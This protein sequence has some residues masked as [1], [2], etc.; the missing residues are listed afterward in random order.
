MKIKTVCQQTGLSDRTVRYY[1]E[2][3]L[4]SPRYTENYLGRKTFDFSPEEVKGLQDI[5]VLRKFGFSIED[6]RR[7]MLN[8][9]ESIA[10][11]SEVRQRKQELIAENTVALEALCRLDG[12]KV[13]TVAELAED[14]AAPAM[15]NPLPPEDR[16]ERVERLLWLL[17]KRLPAIVLAGLP[18]VVLVAG[19]VIHSS[20]AYPVWD[21]K[22]RYGAFLLLLPTICILL[23][24]LPRCKPL[25]ERWETV[26]KWVRGI[27]L[28]LCAL[29]VPVVSFSWLV[30]FS[31]GPSST[32]NPDAYLLLDEAC[33]AKS[34]RIFRELF[35]QT[36]P[37]DR[38]YYYWYE[39]SVSGEKYD[40]CAQWTLPREEFEAEVMRVEELFAQFCALKQNPPPMM[41]GSNLEPAT[42]QEGKYTCLIWY[43]RRDD[44]MP[45]SPMS[46]DYVVYIFDYHPSTR[47][48]RYI[49]CES[50]QSGDPWYLE[51][52]W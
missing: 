44:R 21:G 39:E 43:Q 28:V 47:Q 22:K 51:M 7:M 52:D 9:W 50:T 14:L 13:Y 25:T 49:L 38:E 1:I 6:I 40:I 23:L 31:G 29:Y 20:Y 17:L 32:T 19:L 3:G 15:D 30:F 33:P 4:I 12:N 16:L 46:G 11:I 37:E 36:A 45:F 24:Y 8:P 18:L 26:R 35:P 5:A 2:E 10:V 42:I 34:Y 41:E 27:V 48:V